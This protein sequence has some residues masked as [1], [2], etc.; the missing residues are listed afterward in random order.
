MAA[1]CAAHAHR[2]SITSARACNGTTD[3]P[4][5]N[6]TPTAAQSKKSSNPTVPKN[7]TKPVAKPSKLRALMDD[8]EAPSALPAVVAAAV[9]AKKSKLSSLLDDDETPPAS[10][11]QPVI[12][13]VATPVIEKKAAKRELPPE[14]PKVAIPL[15]GVSIVFCGDSPV[16]IMSGASA[17]WADLMCWSIN[18]QTTMQL[19]RADLSPKQAV[20]E[21]IAALQQHIKIQSKSRT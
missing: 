4:A 6:A 7:P 16:M 21:T 14:P 10:A 12:D 20:D 19:L 11:K 8:D 18:L 15:Q 9:S 5:K 17:S 13:V 1:W 3:A 2:D